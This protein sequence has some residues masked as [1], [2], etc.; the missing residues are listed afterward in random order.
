VAVLEPVEISVTVH[1]EG[2]VDAAALRPLLE[3]AVAS[4]R[5]VIVDLAGVTDLATSAVGALLR[6]RHAGVQV[7][8]VN[9][10][11]PVLAVLRGTG[12]A[13]LLGVSPG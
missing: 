2:A 10:S 6:V 4:G 5:D 8:C 9:A 12:A 13:L 1:P 7:T 3:P 11:R